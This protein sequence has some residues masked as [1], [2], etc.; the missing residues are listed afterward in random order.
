MTDPM[1]SGQALKEAAYVA[2]GFGV[3]GVQ[4]AQVR[5]VELTRELRRRRQQWEQEA[6][7]ARA[8]LLALARGVD[9]QLDPVIRQVDVALDRV[10]E[11]LPGPARELVHDA[12][13]LARE[14]RA[15]MRAHL[16]QADDTAA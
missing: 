4:R 10:E 9:E 12:H 1:P 8:Q 6:A 5:R 11:R 7:G 2:L 14:A 13:S 15:Q 16:A 3:M